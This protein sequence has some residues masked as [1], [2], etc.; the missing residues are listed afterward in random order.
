M[1]GET[2][3]KEFILLV[4]N[5]LIKA[6]GRNL[7]E[8]EWDLF[9][10]AIRLHLPRSRS[11]PHL[12]DSMKWVFKTYTISRKCYG[13]TTGSNP[14]SVGS[15]PTWDAKFL[16]LAKCHRCIGACLPVLLQ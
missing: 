7:F 9:L 13:S 8:D 10:R 4:Y 12:V 14:V 1:N 16:H 5:K 3:N 11:I 2:T 6:I 15:T